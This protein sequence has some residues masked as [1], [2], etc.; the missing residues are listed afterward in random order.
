[1]QRA[2]GSLRVKEVL[3]KIVIGIDLGAVISIKD[4]IAV[5][6]HMVGVDSQPVLHAPGVDGMQEKQAGRL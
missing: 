4:E 1:M 2:D 6:V 3:Q 5:Q